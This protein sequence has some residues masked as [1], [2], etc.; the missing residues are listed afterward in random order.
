VLKQHLQDAYDNTLT[1]HGH[2]DSSEFQENSSAG[3]RWAFKPDPPMK[4]HR[5][6]CEIQ[7]QCGRAFSGRTVPLRCAGVKW[8]KNK[9]LHFECYVNAVA[10]N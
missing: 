6:L 9:V 1:D 10:F 8:S 3:V 4:F 2:I 7:T 5:F